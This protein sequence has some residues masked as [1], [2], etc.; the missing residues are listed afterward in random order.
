MN[1]IN[2]L[3]TYIDLVNNASEY[4]TTNTLENI[5]NNL[6]TITPEQLV[7]IRNYNAVLLQAESIEREQIKN[8]LV[9][10]VANQFEQYV[11]QL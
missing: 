3:S 8:N 7:E 2:K 4:V 5:L 11:S 9:Q 10:R 1:D 6:N